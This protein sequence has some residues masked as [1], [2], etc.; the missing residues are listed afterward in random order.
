MV[1]KLYFLPAGSC[2]L[3]QSAVNGKLPPG[4]LIEMPVWC[5]L[6]E[7]EEGPFL[8]DTGMPDPFVNNP[9]YYN[10]TRREGRLVP[11]MTEDD[12]IVN[13]LKRMGYQTGDIQAVISSHL[14]LDHSGGN[15]HFPRTPII[16][17]KSEFESAMGNDDYSPYECRLP[18]LKY[19]LIEGDYEPA[20][21]IRI[22]HTPGHAPGHQS[23][24]V[25]TEKTGYVL[26]TLDVAYNKEIFE[27]DLPFLSADARMA[28]KSIRSLQKLVRD[29]KPEVVF[30]GHDG[31]QAK[32]W[33]TLYPDFL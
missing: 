11:N 4:R 18:D 12:R 26:L 19:Q 24:L 5:F 21:G 20:P 29:V 14:H 6:V 27:N 23:V 28:S 16:I 1:K 15:G 9:G 31:E 17:Q 33:R 13:I 10:G 2:F 3:D 7:T 22:L 8:I 32:N 25:K 30:F